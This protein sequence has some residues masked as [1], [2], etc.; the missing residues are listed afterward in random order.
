MNTYLPLERFSFGTGDRFVHQAAAQLAAVQKARDAGTEIAIVWNKSN[1]E[2]KTI[3]TGPESTR[4]AGEAAAK[5]AGW[6]KGYY[7]DA[8]HITFETVD[9]F[10]PH[11]TFFTLD[12]AEEIGQPADTASINTFL[13]AA[14]PYL[15]TEIEIPGMKEPLVIPHARAVAAAGAFLAATQAAGKLYQKIAAAKD[16]ATFVTEVSMDEVDTPQGPEDILLILLALSLQEVPIQTLAPR[17]SG[18]FNK[19]VDYVGEVQQ[20]RTEFEADMLVLKWAAEEF[21]FPPTLK[22]SVHSG[23]DKFAIYPVIRELIKKHNLGLHIKTAGT[24]WLEEIIGLAEAGGSGLTLAQDVYAVCLGRIDE[25]AGP[26]A[27]VI[28]IKRDKLPT[29]AQ[30]RAMSSDQMARSLRHNQADKLYNPSMRQLMHVGYKVAAEMGR[31]YLDALEK[32]EEVIAKN[33]TENLWDRHL[34]LLF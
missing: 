11:C 4:A 28:D 10:I 31:T 15:D 24:T 1:R 22:L 18:R 5:A 19:G 9:R 6:T 32:H 30:V 34:K 33:V 17:F 8:D 26:Y 14:A 7:F 27:S 16:P 23:S 2:H 21:D 20:F 12:V 13:H 3:G 25:L 29:E